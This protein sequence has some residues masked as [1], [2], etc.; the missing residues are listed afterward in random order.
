MPDGPSNDERWRRIKELFGLAAGQPAGE[1]AAWLDAKCVGDAELRA[2]VET[3]L[4]AHRAAGGFIE[5]PAIAAPGAAQAVAD[6]VADGPGRDPMVGRRFGPYRIVSELA[7][8]G[9][10]VVYLA[11]RDDDVF[12]RRVAIKVVQGGAARPEVA[13]RFEAERRILASLEHPNIARLLDAGTADEGTPFVVMEY[14]EGTPIDVYVRERRLPLAQR[15]ELFCAVCDGVQYSHQRLV[16]HRDIKPRNIL[17]TDEGVPKLL[18]FGIAKLLEPSGAGVDATRTEF[19]VL[20]PDYASPEQV[21]GEPITVASDV[22]SLGVLLYSLLTGRSPYGATPRTDVDLLRTICEIDPARPSDAIAHAGAGA[23]GG[24]DERSPREAAERRRELRG[25]LDLI[26][27]KA[28]SKEPERRYPSVERLADDVRRHLRRE[29]VQAAPDSWRYRSGKF[30]HRHRIGVAAAAA[31]TLAV[32]LGLAGTLVEARSAR[33]ER[34]RAVRRFNDVEGLARSVMFE[35]NDAIER[36]PGSTAARE[37]LVRRA[38]QYLD[39]LAADEGTDPSLQRELAAAYLRIGDVQGDSS[40]SNLGHTQA[41]LESYRKA[42]AM[43]ERLAA[44]RPADEGAL[45]ELATAHRDVGLQLARTGDPKG[46]LAELNA[47]VGIRQRLL[48]AH[49]GER[50]RQFALATMYQSVGDVLVTLEDWTGVLA[51]RQK[52]LE[53]IRR[54]AAT[55]PGDADLQRALAL[56]YKRLGAIQTKLDHLPEG[57]EAYRQALAIDEA[58]LVLEPG[59]AQAR[60]DV[61]YGVSDVGLI[62]WRQGD[63]RAALVQYSRARGL[64]EALAE[65]DPKDHRAATALT[66]TLWR[67]AA[68]HRQLGEHDTA[69][70]EFREAI[71]LLEKLAASDPAD[72]ALQTQF[73]AVLEQTGTEY[74]DLRG[75]RPGACVD[76]RGYLGR[77]LAVYRGLEAKQPLTGSSAAAPA[78]V[79]A[80][81]VRCAANGK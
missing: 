32:V 38:L 81:L 8:G 48:A 29:P 73:A 46:G 49:P 30:V 41:S 66:S 5:T 3:L 37:L 76:A 79:E 57:L 31:F 77:A 14:V 69:I 28:L 33:L 1:L 47:A 36:L 62:L 56:A 54:A 65:A 4:E 74:S 72:V 71:A 61:S 7:R 21:R 40:R 39:R 9:M 26:T 70:A 13:A 55:A 2:Q 6:A 63:R 60:M 45:D 17:V 68:L 27:M 43:L 22:Y 59:S 42:L 78:R 50:S 25:D 11:E 20:T 64:R 15:L 10:G 58:R 23:G 53:P 75:R 67:L 18:D 16:V 24:F 35:L 44:A 80:E 52:A 12:Q 34:E 19:R 51:M